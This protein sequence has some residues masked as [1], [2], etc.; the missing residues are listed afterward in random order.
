MRFNTEQ[1]NNPAFRTL[2]EYYL[3]DPPVDA[4]SVRFTDEQSDSVASA[5]LLAQLSPV[6]KCALRN[7]AFQRGAIDLGL[8]R[9][10]FETVK[11]LWLRLLT[12]H[13]HPPELRCTSATFAIKLLIALDM[14]QFHASVVNSVTE[15]A[16]WKLGMQDV[17]AV[18]TDPEIGAVPPNVLEIFLPTLLEC[19]KTVTIRNPFIQKE[20]D[21]LSA[22]FDPHGLVWINRERSAEAADTYHLDYQSDGKS[23]GVLPGRTLPH[24]PR[25]EKTFTFVETLPLDDTRAMVQFYKNSEDNTHYFMCLDTDTGAMVGTPQRIWD[26]H[27]RMVMN[28]HHFVFSG[29]TTA[30]V[31]RRTTDFFH[32]NADYFHIPYQVLELKPKEMVHVLCGGASDLLFIESGDH[33]FTVTVLRCRGRDDDYVRQYVIRVGAESKPYELLGGLVLSPTRVVLQFHLREE[34]N[35]QL[36]MKLQLFERDAPVCPPH[37]MGVSAVSTFTHLSNHRDKIGDGRLRH[38]FGRIYF[39]C[40][41]QGLHAYDANTNDFAEPL[42]T[43]P[44]RGNAALLDYGARLLVLPADIHWEKSS[45]RLFDPRTGRMAKDHL[46]TRMTYVHKTITLKGGNVLFATLEAEFHIL[47]RVD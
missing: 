25:R 1:F 41:N 24:K 16:Q 2:C 17:I 39:F 12:S 28:A 38:K 15:H 40:D 7:T 45:V 34:S 33:P 18:V 30:Q 14:L 8:T 44:M 21:A 31:F 32:A 43:V 37:D 13:P 3:E 11:D 46:L 29:T 22:H 4:A 26:V 10:Q 27:H 35:Y 19:P 9:A 47:K 6:W 23:M 5:S 20:V 36:R 42:F